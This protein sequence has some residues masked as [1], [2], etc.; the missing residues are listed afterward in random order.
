MKKVHPF[1]LADLSILHNYL[2]LLEEFSLLYGK[3]IES[4]KQSE[5]WPGSRTPIPSA[6]LHLYGPVSGQSLPDAG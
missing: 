2:I 1:N 6:T 4:L 5:A 3:E